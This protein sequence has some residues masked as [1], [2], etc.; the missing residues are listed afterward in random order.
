M[1]DCIGAM[2]MM[3]A[4]WAEAPI[5]DM[6]ERMFGL[7]HMEMMAPRAQQVG[8]SQLAGAWGSIRQWEAIRRLGADRV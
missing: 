5:Q 1:H 2:R 8:K 6:V 7:P 3:D 4:S